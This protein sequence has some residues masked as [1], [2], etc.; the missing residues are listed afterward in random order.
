MADAQDQTRGGFKRPAREKVNRSA[1][2]GKLTT[3][4][5]QLTVRSKAR[6]RVNIGLALQRWRAVKTG[7]G[8]KSDREVAVYLLDAMKRLSSRPASSGAS[9]KNVKFSQSEVLTLIKQ[10]V[11][12]A[13]RKNETKLQ[14]LIETIQQLD[15]GVDYKSSIQKLEARINTATKRAEAALAYMTKTQKK[16]PLP[17]RVNVGTIRPHSKD[18]AVQTESQIDKKSVECMD[19][20]GA[21]FQMIETTKKEL[22]KLH[23]DN[24]ALTAAITDLSEEPPPMVLTPYG[25]CECKEVARVIKK[26][27]EDQQEKENN[28][29]EP[30]A[31]RV[32]VERLSPGNSN[33]GKH[34]DSKLEELSYP[35][36]PPT[37]FS[38]ILN[39]EA[40]SFS[41]PQRPEV[42]LALIRNPA[43]LSVLWNVEKKDP[44]APPMESY[45]VLMTMEKVKGSGVFPTWKTLGEVTAITLPMCVMISKY[46]PGHKVCVAVVGKDK[47]GRYGP[48]SKVVTA[49]IPG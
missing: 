35:P 10:E 40:A 34:T 1:K 17:P 4:S 29:E 3:L 32:R 33:D 2:P 26:E 14:G 8:L 27:P 21:F 24:E 23:A 44:S 13:L 9:E 30:K 11:S 38:P 16:S 20:S 6:A 12:R 15:Q 31:E 36:L 37:T 22:K 42:H 46:K 7:N 25:S 45:S 5:Q 43:G 48:Y 19:K 49:A 28:V 41:I 39:V 47:F 18:E